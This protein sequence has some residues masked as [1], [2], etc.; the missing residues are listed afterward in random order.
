MLHAKE[1]WLLEREEHRTLHAENVE[2]D[3]CVPSVFKRR[4]QVGNGKRSG[5]QE[6]N[7]SD[8]TRGSASS[9]AKACNSMAS[10]RVKTPVVQRALYSSRSPMNLTLTQQNPW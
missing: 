9:R 5:P 1:R 4:E 6:R 7:A 8:R 10:S 3:A 2:C